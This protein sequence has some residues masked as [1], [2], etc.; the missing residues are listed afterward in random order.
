MGAPSSYISTYDQ[1]D[2]VKQQ[3]V[4]VCTFD[5]NFNCDEDHLRH[6]HYDPDDGRY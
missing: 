4:I 3:S 6:H 5:Y 1:I 2:K